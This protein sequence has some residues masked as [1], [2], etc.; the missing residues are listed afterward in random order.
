[1]P[2]FR[3]F[4]TITGALNFL[5][6]PFL[7]ISVIADPVPGVFVS[8]I[9]LSAFLLGAGVTL[10]WAGRDVAARA[11]VIFWNGCARV[12]T[13]ASIF[14]AAANGLA[15]SYEYAFALFDGIVGLTYIIGAIRASDKSFTQLALV[16]G[17]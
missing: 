12:L 15:N 7:A 11:P 3:K 8:L 17:L 4:V 1:M 9:S 16:R 6:A 10:I 2:L 13:V 5:F 14:Y